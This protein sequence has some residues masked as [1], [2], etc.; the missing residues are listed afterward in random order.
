V[1][2]GLRF[3]VTTVLFC[4]VVDPDDHSSARGDKGI[5]GPA[6]GGGRHAVQPHKRLHLWCPPAGAPRCRS[7]QT[8]A[9][10]VDLRF[11]SPRR[12]GVHDLLLLFMFTM[13]QFPALLPR[14][15]RASASTRSQTHCVPMSERVQLE[16]EKLAHRIRGL[17]QGGAGGLLSSQQKR[18]AVVAPP[19]VLRVLHGAPPQVS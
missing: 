6:V 1:S 9:R 14:Y 10:V 5:L 13:Q 8:P 7:D 18:C 19:E 4:N 17:P 12:A 15:D 3:A 2:P 16:Q 11:V